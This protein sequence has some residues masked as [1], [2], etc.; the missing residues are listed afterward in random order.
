MTRDFNNKASPTV[1]QEVV[2]ELLRLVSRGGVITK[3]AWSVL[4]ETLR[5]DPGL[6]F[7]LAAAR[8][9]YQETLKKGE[10]HGEESR[11]TPE[12]KRRGRKRKDAQDEPR[13]LRP[14]VE[15]AVKDG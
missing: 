13:L 6:R 11:P 14:P 3:E 10:A 12:K 5:N 7:R 9:R 2:T 1:I 4:P 15:R 8:S